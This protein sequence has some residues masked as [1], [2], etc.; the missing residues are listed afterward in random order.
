MFSL[1]NCGIRAEGAAVLFDALTQNNSLSQFRYVIVEILCINRRPILTCVAFT[2]NSL[3]ENCIGPEGMKT[4]A[5]A[6]QHNVG[7]KR[8]E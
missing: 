2:F 7:L 4:L 5:T 3:N 1:D 8:L 6:L